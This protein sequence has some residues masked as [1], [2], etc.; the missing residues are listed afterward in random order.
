MDISTEK[1]ISRNQK[2]AKQTK[3]NTIEAVQLDEVPASTPQSN[4]EQVEFTEN[5]QVELTKDEHTELT[6]EVQTESTEEVQTELTEEV[7][8]VYKAVLVKAKSLRGFWRCGLFWSNEGS[9]TAVINDLNNIPVG[10]NGM[11]FISNIQLERL[12]NEPML[13]VIPVHI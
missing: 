5:E 4:S 2:K 6:E 8:D 11:P 12:Q 7:Q 1:S 3:E 10:A 13:L 9:Y